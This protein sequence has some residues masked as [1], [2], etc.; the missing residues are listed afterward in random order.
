[1]YRPDS[2]DL[3]LSRRPREILALAADGSAEVSVSG[4]ADRPTVQPATWTDEDGV[5]VVRV[6]RGGRGRKVYRIVHVAADRIL[7]TE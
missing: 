6:G 1:M 3:P 5:V 7:V 4:P 2:V